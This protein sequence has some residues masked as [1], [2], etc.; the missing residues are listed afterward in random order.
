MDAQSLFSIARILLVV[1]LLLV[2]LN[3]YLVFKL[4][5]FDPFAKWSANKI[6]GFLML[7]FMVGGLIASLWASGAWYDA[8]MLVTNAASEHGEAID[9]MFW[10]TM[11]VVMLVF[12]VTNAVLFYFAFK[13]RGDD[14]LGRKAYFFHH[15][16][17]L[18]II[19]TVVPAI[20]M[21]ILVI[22]GVLVWHAVM[23]PAPEDA[24][25]VEVT[26]KQFA[27]TIR[28]PGQD[29]TFGTALV[30]NIDEAAGNELGFD[31]ED[32]N[33]QDDFIADT[34]F[35][36]IGKPVE[37]LIRS[38]DVLHSPTLPHFRVK[39]DAVP[40]MT[41]KF[42]FIPTKTT[43]QMREILNDTTFNYEM[44]CQ[45]VCGGGHYNMRKVIVVDTEENYEKWLKRQKSFFAMYEEMNGGGVEEAPEEEAETAPE[46]EAPVEGEGEQEGEAAEND[47][48][49]N[50]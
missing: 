45:E 28:Y 40:G 5:K 36:P 47:L 25:Q 42:W 10:I 23:S 33:G 7:A 18:E 35:I 43:A 44:S 38:R 15:N 19:W 1:V 11:V 24:I 16:D 13:Y 20:V 46:G 27:W 22:R 9:S 6:N 30:R 50:Q 4:K 14:E 31:L 49:L 8:Y 32:K 37:L 41:T 2:C 29:N 26:G 17:R 48:A 39:M 21:T 12:I 34:M 3:L